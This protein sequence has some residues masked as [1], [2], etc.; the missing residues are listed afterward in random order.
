M[1]STLEGSTCVTGFSAPEVEAWSGRFCRKGFPEEL[2]ADGS[3]CVPTRLEADVVQETRVP[4]VSDL[5]KA[6]AA[7][8]ASL[9]SALLLYQES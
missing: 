1:P 8:T 6:G 4:E 7:A 5:V 3:L 2:D 9:A